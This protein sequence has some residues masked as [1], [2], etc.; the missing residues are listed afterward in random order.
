MLRA[1]DNRSTHLIKSLSTGTSHDLIGRVTRGELTKI[2]AGPPA[3]VRKIAIRQGLQFLP[4]EIT[5]PLFAGRLATG[6]G[7]QRYRDGGGENDH[8]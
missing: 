3:R 7:L 1:H 6:N 5:R 2:S 8:Q 4:G